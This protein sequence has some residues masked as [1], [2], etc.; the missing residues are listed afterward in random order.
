MYDYITG[1]LIRSSNDSVVVDVSGVGYKIFVPCST[2]VSLPNY[3]TTVTFFISFIIRE[4]SQTLY[5]FL[6]AGQR[7]VFE[8]LL[9]VNGIGP[10]TALSVVGHMSMIELHEALVK[11]DIQALSRVPGIGKK[12]AERLSLELKDI[13][14]ATTTTLPSNPLKGI[15]LDAISA[16][17]HLGYSHTAAQKAVK[18]VVDTNNEL[19]DLSALIT[20]SLKEV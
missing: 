2:T 20:L 6:E 7:D 3:S 16:L 18:K 13:I 1:K 4:F 17:V 12:T 10:K 14:V 15:T 19:A 9:A 8:R 5:G 11:K